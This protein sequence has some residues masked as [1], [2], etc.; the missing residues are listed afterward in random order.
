MIEG[1]RLTIP[2]NVP[3]LRS[4]L[5]PLYELRPEDYNRIINELTNLLVLATHLLQET[6]NQ[7]FAQSIIR[8]A[9]RLLRNYDDDVVEFVKG[10]SKLHSKSHRTD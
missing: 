8:N 7:E 2:D 4:D 10:L 1:E 5:A 9:A 3:Q 6:G